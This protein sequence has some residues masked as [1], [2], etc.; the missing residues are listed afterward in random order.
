MQLTEHVTAVHGM[1]PM[2]VPMKQSQIETPITPQATLMPD[3][4]TTPTRRRIVT[5]IQTGVLASPSKAL[6]AAL[7]AFGKKWVMNGAMGVESNVA[8]ID[9]SVV[10]SANTTVARAGEKSAPART[11]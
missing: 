2:K 4:G 7:R 9:P 1:E 5:R 10:R 6:R 8:Q 3:Q 11:F